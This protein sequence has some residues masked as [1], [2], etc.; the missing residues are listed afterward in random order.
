MKTAQIEI[1]KKELDLYGFISRNWC[2]KHFISRLG[3]II[4]RLKKE[5]YVFSTRRIDGDYAYI[6]E[7][8]PNEAEELRLQKLIA[9]AEDRD[10]S[11][12]AEEE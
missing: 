3:A 5:G 4:C 9:E 8:T 11:L 7:I 1:V 2:L 10:R 12:F 6:L